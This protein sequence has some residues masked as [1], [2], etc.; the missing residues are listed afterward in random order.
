[1]QEVS[2]AIREGADGFFAVQYSLIAKLA[3]GL[4]VAIYVIYRYTRTLH[5]RYALTSRGLQ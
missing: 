5:L 3:V 2:D 4:A 1:M